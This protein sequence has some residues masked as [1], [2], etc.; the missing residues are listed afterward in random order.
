MTRNEQILK[1]IEGIDT[2]A[3]W[4]EETESMKLKSAKVLM[5][6]DNYNENMIQATIHHLVSKSQFNFRTIFAEEF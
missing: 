1:A 4:V 6:Y 3:A 5:G 2:S